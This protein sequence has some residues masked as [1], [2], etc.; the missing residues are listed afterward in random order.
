MATRFTLKTF[1]GTHLIEKYEHRNGIKLRSI[2][3]QPKHHMAGQT[4]PWGEPLKNPDRFEIFDSQMNKIFNGNITEAIA[5]A[6]KV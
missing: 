5:F 1:Y 4:G 6:S 3:A 2:L